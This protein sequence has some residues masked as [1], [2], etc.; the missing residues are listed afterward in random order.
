M[1]KTVLGLIALFFTCNIVKSQTIITPGAARMEAYL[2][3]LKGKAVAIFANQTSLV[4]GIHLI[5]TLVSR[6]IKV[7]KIFGPEH[8][9][10]GN[11]DAGEHIG[12]TKDKKTKSQ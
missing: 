8:G 10:R 4:G 12:D 9:F 2:P 7:V 5:D 1:K 11:A 6:G 3:Y